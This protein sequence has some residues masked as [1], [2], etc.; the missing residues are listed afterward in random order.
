MDYHFIEYR[1]GELVKLQILINE[2]PVDALTSIVHKAMRSI[3]DRRWS[4]S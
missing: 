3:K 1:A 2:E 4:A